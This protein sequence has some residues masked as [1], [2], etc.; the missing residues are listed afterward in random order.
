MPC[1]HG[2]D[3][4]NCPTCRLTKFSIPFNGKNLKGLQEN[5]LEPKNPAF[6]KNLSSKELIVNDVITNRLSNIPKSI[7]IISKPTMFNDLPE[8]QNKM[9][10]ERLNEIDITKADKFKISKKIAL[11]SPEW[12]FNKED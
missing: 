3:E 11:E 9:F 8:F 4:I 10:L 7:D 5:P 1:I 2:L 12:K 6:K